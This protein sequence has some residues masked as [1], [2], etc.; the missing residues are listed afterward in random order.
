MDGVAGSHSGPGERGEVRMNMKNKFPLVVAKSNLAFCYSKQSY[1][2]HATTSI[3]SIPF[4]T[5][6]T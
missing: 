4:I 1:N 5:A 2:E 3:D 6:P